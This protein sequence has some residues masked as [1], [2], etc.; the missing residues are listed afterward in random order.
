[1][2][3]GKKEEDGRKKGGRNGSAIKTLARATQHELKS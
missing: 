3:G 1:M 2:K